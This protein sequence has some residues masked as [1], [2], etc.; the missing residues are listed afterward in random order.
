MVNLTE[1]SATVFPQGSIHFE[2]NPSCEPAMFVAAFNNQDP[3]VSTVATNFFGLP[4]EIVGASLG[5]LGIEDVNDLKRML[6]ANPALGVEECQR[7]CGLTE[8]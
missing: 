6:P 8:D 2:F 5:G 4:A 1:G 3:G 7:R